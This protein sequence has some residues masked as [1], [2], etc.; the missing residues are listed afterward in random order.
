MHELPTA[1][2]SWVDG[3]VGGVGW[4]QEG[5]GVGRGEPCEVGGRHRPAAQDRVQTPPVPA[6]QLTV[7]GV[8]ACREGG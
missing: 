4:R 8:G 7:T 6:L 1:A 5:G 2:N 3:A